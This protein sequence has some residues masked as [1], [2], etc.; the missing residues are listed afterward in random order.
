MHLKYTSRWA[1]NVAHSIHKLD[2]H[3]RSAFTWSARL[4][5]L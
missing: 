4:S 1:F 3:I 5:R 2:P